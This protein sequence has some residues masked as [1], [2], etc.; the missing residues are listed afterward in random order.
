MEKIK[1]LITEDDQAALSQ[2]AKFIGREGFETLTAETGEQALELFIKERP[3]IILTDC[4]LP[5]MSG[6]ELMKK[7]RE[8]DQNHDTEI[9]INTAFGTLDMAISAIEAGAVDYIKKPLDLDQLLVA[10]GRA[11]EKI[12]E[13]HK[14]A[15]YPSILLAE[16]EKEARDL[17]VKYLKK[18]KNDWNIYSA[19]NGEEVLQIFTSTKIDVVV[20]DV[21]MPN[22]NGI[23]ALRE[24]RAISD[25]FMAI[26]MTGFG[27]EDIAIQALREGAMS[28]LKKPINI[29]ELLVYLESAV[30]RIKNQRTLKFRIRES[31]LSREIV[32][33]ITNEK[34]IIINAYRMLS[35]NIAKFAEDVIDTLPIGLI[36]VTQ[37]M[38]ISYMNSQFK[39]L[40]GKCTELDES[41]VQ[42]LTKINI[43][44]SLSD[45]NRNIMEMFEAKENAIRK[46]NTGQFSYLAVMQITLIES[47]YSP[48]GNAVLIALR[49]AH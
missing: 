26:I 10:I 28:F 17:L 49:G 47:R 23:D 36:M 30:D 31:E 34:K 43:K 11:Q 15:T 7:V 12:L 35:G 4:K 25:D 27:E 14:N 37:G 33:R 24:M 1:V 40:F 9:I 19:Q 3:N 42:Q 29:E 41:F 39:R 22:K 21:N 5:G 18:E 16:D 8:L 13:R 46:I 44:I 20:L 48:L 6:I 2:L 38:K 32:A 45:L